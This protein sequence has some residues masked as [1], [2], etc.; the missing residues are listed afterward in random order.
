M[1]KLATGLI[2]IVFLSGC[3]TS[4]VP[5]RVANTYEVAGKVYCDTPVFSNLE[6]MIV[7]WIQA[8]IAPEWEPVCQDRRAEE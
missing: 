2:L 5:A 1:S 3:A 6:N 4:E 7:R 8:T